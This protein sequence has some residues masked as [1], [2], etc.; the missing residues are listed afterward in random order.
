MKSILY[1]YATPFTTGLF[2]VSLV[3]GVALFFHVGPAA[4]HGMHEWLSM[5]L[6][7]PFVLH[8]WRNWRPMLSYFKHL[9]MAIALVL[10]LV[11]AGIFF[12][13]TGEGGAG[14]PPQMVFLQKVLKGKVSDVA[15]LL[16]ATPD[17]IVAKLN[18]SGMTAT[19]DDTL[20]DVAA[21][22][23]KSDMHLLEVLNTA[24]KPAP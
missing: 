8:M 24:S 18:A 17:A 4:F 23:G 15:P 10:S 7:L 5:V 1:R 14:G 11:A 2:L 16:G 21:K 3:S 20:H 19:A 22:A 13:P 6:I 9:P 12:I